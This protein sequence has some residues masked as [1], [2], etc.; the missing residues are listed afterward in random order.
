[1]LQL[2]IK[3]STERVVGMVRGMMFGLAV[4]RAARKGRMARNFI[5]VGMLVR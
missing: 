1:M 5:S 2:R 3:F 4:A